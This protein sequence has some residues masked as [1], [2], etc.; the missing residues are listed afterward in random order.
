MPGPEVENIELR[1]TYANSPHNF[2]AHNMDLDF[3][4][5]VSHISFILNNQTLN[6]VRNVSVG[7]IYAA[8]YQRSYFR[9]RAVYVYPTGPDGQPDV[10]IYYMDYGNTEN[11]AMSQLREVPSDVRQYP[12]L[13]IKCTLAHVEPSLGHAEW[14]KDART[15]FESV[16]LE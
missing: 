14:T 15:F 5:L 10:K 2:Y 6:I 11:V 8:P 9:A 3:Q 7:E 16:S 12:E 1:V 13:A 4:K